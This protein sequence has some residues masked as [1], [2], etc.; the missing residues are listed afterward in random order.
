MVLL[1]F[2]VRL[3]KATAAAAAAASQPAVAAPVA[4]RTG[5]DLLKRVLRE[6]LRYKYIN[7]GLCLPPPTPLPPSAR[8]S[9]LLFAFQLKLLQPRR[10]RMKVR[11]WSPDM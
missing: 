11:C 9:F 5:V 7:N 4:E 8:R 1:Y 6:F 3:K 10:T 2:M